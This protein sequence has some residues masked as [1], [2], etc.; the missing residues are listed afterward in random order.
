MAKFSFSHRLTRVIFQ[1]NCPILLNNKRKH[2]SVFLLKLLKY[3]KKLIRVS[4]QISLEELK[5]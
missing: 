1:L 3:D 2:F 4:Y 5:F